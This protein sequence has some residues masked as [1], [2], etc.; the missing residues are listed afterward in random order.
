LFDL[1]SDK[2]CTVSDMYHRGWDEGGDA[3]G[4]RR[5]LWAWEETLLGE[6]RDLLANVF[7]QPNVSD[8]WQWDPDIRDGYTVNGAYHILTTP[9]TTMDADAT[10]DLVWHK[11]V[12]LKVSLV[13]WRLLKDR[14]PTKINLQR[15]G[16]LQAD[17]ITCVSGCGIE[18]SA[19]HLFFHCKEFGSLWHYIK[20]WIGVAGVDPLSI[21]EHFTQ[22]INYTGYSNK[23]KSFLQMI[24]LLGVWLIWNERNNRIFNNIEIPI[25]Q[26]LEKV[27]FHS[28]WWLKASNVS[29]V[30]GSQRWWSDPLMC[31]GIA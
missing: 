13:A 12:P 9:V 10:S 18:E 23:R 17:D 5:R 6:C 19:S 1:A 24:W 4:W 2:L 25:S 7:V 29:F 21:R 26:L 31:L 14:L 20:S 28:Y 11:Q 15:R 16:L 3:W 22:F 8:R 30:Y 27:K